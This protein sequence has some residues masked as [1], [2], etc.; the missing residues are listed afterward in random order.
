MKVIGFVYRIYLWVVFLECLMVWWY[1]NKALDKKNPISE[2]EISMVLDTSENPIDL[3]SLLMKF[4][5]W[6]ESNKF[7]CGG[8]IYPLDEKG[9]RI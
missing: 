5:D 7:Y 8:T 1:M 4:I 6:V 9:E 3:D 2:Y